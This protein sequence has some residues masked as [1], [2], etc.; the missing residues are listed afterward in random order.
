MKPMIA[1]WSLLAVVAATILAVCAMAADPPAA[2]TAGPPMK[3]VCPSCH[4]MAAGEKD[5][6]KEMKDM[7]KNAGISDEMLMQRRAMASAPLYMDEP[8]VLLGM[9]KDLGLSDEQKDKL[10]DIQKEARGKAKAVLTEQQQ[11]KVGTVSEKPMAM[12]ECMKQMHEKMKPVMAKMKMEGKMM[13]MACPMMKQTMEP[14]KP[15]KPVEAEPPTPTEGEATE[16][17]L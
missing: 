9:A 10:T 14:P 6:S 12:M 1:V 2:E 17:E 4:M 16:P 3:D 8:A 13:P 7:M 5:M 15:A 11:K